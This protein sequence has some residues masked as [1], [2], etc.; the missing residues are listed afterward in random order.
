M[1][2]IK[3]LSPSSISTFYQDRIEFYLKYCADN[4]PPRLQQTTAMA[5]GSAFDAF[6]K[7]YLV[8]ALHG[9]VSPEFEIEAIFEA[10]VEEHNRDWAFENGEHLFKLYKQSGA[11][12]DLMIELE[13]AVTEPQ[14]EF[15]VQGRI[16]HD[17]YVDGIPLLGKPDLHFK[18]KSDTNVILDWKVNGYCGKRPKS[19]AKGYIK[20][21]DSWNDVYQPSRNNGQPHK[22]CQPMMIDGLNVNIAHKLE[23]VDKSWAKQTT[24]YLWLLGEPVGTKAI[25]GIDQLCGVP[26]DGQL[27]DIR[28]ATH[29]CRISESFQLELLSQ[30]HEVWDAIQ[31]GHIFTDLSVEENDAKCLQLD[32]YHK[33]FS[34]ETKS[35]NEDWDNW[36]D[37]SIRK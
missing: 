33:A 13:Q 24:I 25:A 15:T 14:F 35:G 31:T 36:F 28:V 23:A 32:E 6:V 5:A 3:Y 29:R 21:R 10:Q 18:T 16:S 19:P 26:R 11:L 34:E 37:N 20:C 17:K 22:D 1:R 4:R 7:N 27:P 9:S 2:D 8:Y 12:A 30:I